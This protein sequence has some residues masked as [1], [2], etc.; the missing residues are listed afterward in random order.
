MDPELIETDKYILK[1]NAE[2]QFLEYLIKEGVTVDVN[3]VI[4][5]KKKVVKL[6]P[7]VKFYVWA[8]GVEFFTLTKEA[9]ELCATKEYLDNVLAIAFYTKNISVMLLGKV[10]NKINK[11]AVTT[12][13]FNN[14]NR[15]RKWLNQ[16]MQKKGN[17][18]INISPFEL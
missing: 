6:C 4:E 11:P 8:E 7:G 2:K 18:T 9:R 5:S 3:T 13:I 17:S 12:R 16:Q 10:F 1:I 15:A 14:R